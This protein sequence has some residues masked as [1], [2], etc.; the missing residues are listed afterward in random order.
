MHSHFWPN[1]WYE[2]LLNVNLHWILIKHV[3]LFVILS[4]D[5]QKGNI[6]CSLL[7]QAINLI[8]SWFK[9]MWLP[10]HW[11]SFGSFLVFFQNQRFNASCLLYY[12]E[13]KHGIFY[14]LLGWFFSYRYLYALRFSVIHVNGF[15]RSI[16]I[17]TTP[18]K[19]YKKTKVHYCD[20]VIFHDM[21]MKRKLC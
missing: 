11:L 18:I 1:Y 19:Y 12:L 9:L 3:L 20:S 8:H 6:N 16:F 21:S 2:F 10:L 7:S 15:S 17:Y 4:E 14:S 13:T 5:S